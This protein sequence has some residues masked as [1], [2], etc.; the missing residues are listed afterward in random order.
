MTSHINKAAANAKNLNDSVGPFVSALNPLRFPR[1]V[2]FVVA[3]VVV[4]SLQSHSCWGTA[5]VGVKVLELHPSLT[6]SYPPSAVGTPSR[7]IGIRASSNHGF[8]DFVSF[9]IR[10]PVL[11]STFFK[12]T[13]AGFGVSVNQARHPYYFFYP[14][15]ASAQNGGFNPAGWS[16]NG[17]GYGYDFPSSKCLSD[18]RCCVRHCIGFLFALFSSGCPA[19]TGTR[20]DYVLTSNG[21][22]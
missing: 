22:N 9:G 5:H 18:E 2:F 17:T 13:T 12:K 20:C 6:N 19:V 8:P 10:H 11:D 15:F 3:F 7:I 16:N 4:F 1:A 14:A 21:V